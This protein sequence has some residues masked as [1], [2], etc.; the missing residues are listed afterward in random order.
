MGVKIPRKVRPKKAPSLRVVA[1][2]VL[3]GVKM[4]RRQAEWAVHLELK[5]LIV[6][7][8]NSMRRVS[9]RTLCD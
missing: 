5:A 1:I 8:K 2:M 3:A 4:R 9:K 6:K 7:T